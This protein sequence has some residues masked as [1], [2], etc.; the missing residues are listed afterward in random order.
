MLRGQAGGMAWVICPPSGGGEC[1]R[2]VSYSAFVPNISYSL[3]F[4]ESL[5]CQDKVPVN[6]PLSNCSSKITFGHSNMNMLRMIYTPLA[7]SN[8]VP[9]TIQPASDSI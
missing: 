9:I 5:G 6:V 3:Y 8:G 2:Y 1:R 7:A 4:F